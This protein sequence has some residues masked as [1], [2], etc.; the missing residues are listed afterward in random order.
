MLGLAVKNVILFTLIVLIFHFLIKNAI[1]DRYPGADRRSPMPLPTAQR[2]NFVGQIRQEKQDGPALYD[3]EKKKMM[4]YIMQE[5]EN[6][7]D[8][9]FAQKIIT[10]CGSGAKEECPAKKD[11]AK[12]PL[13]TTCDANI[14][15]L[16]AED[17]MKV[18]GDCKLP[19]D[20]KGFMLIKEYENEKVL[21]GGALFDGLQ[22]YDSYDDYF[23]QA[24]LCAV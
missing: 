19:Q 23:S 4:S 18:K 11:N 5:S 13:S 22:A 20:H 8:S 14:Q 9:M 21:N 2:E 3:D 17:P 7:L 15:E 10:E 16:K 12:L 1:V 6:D 24:M